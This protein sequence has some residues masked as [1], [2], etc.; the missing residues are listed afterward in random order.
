MI[1]VDV[2]LFSMKRQNSNQQLATL[3]SFAATVF[4]APLSAEVTQ[5]TEGELMMDGQLAPYVVV[6]TRTPLGLDRVSPS[7]DYIS[8]EE[9]EQWQARDLV[10]IIEK[11]PGMIIIESGGIGAQTSLF[12]RGTESNHTAFFL[13]GRRFNTGFGNQYDLSNLSIGTVGNVQVQRGASSVNYGSSG[14]GG[15]IDAQLQS[16]LDQAGT[17]GSIEAEL[18]SND[19]RRGAFT[20]SAGSERFG[21]SVSGSAL[22]TDNERANDAYGTVNLTSRFDYRLNDD[23]SLELVGQYTETFKELPNSIVS[24]TL[25]D[26]QDTE[27]WLLS[28]GIRYAT[29]ELTVHFFYS[30]AR[31][32]LDLFQIKS[33]FGPF[34]GFAYLGDFPISNT[35]KVVSDELNLQADYSVSNVLLVSAGLT[36]R[37]DEARNTN[38]NTFNPLDPAVPYNETFE[39]FGVYAH[40]LWILG[41]IELRGGLRADRYT[42][43]DNELTGSFEF[44]YNIEDLNA[45][46]FAKVATSYAPPGA[47]DIAFDSDP[48]SPLN[49]EQSES[50]E[51]GFRQALLDGDLIYSIVLFH[52]EIEELLSFDPFTFDTFNVED[53]VT[54]GVEF[55]AEYAVTEKLHLGLGYTYL[56]AE[57]DRLNDPH[58]SFAE[59]G[60]D[61][62]DGVRLARRPKHL[63]QLSADYQFTATLRGGIQAI[64]H[65]D[66]EDID[67]VS[68]LQVEAE[69]YLVVR[70]VV[71][72]AVND[73]LTLFAR[74]ENLLDE[75]YAP[76]AGFPALGR[77][78]YL[79]ARWTF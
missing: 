28:P 37:K 71:D 50:Y 52:N 29:D 26:E 67:P 34:P 59:A 35:I 4:I 12:T 48:A 43:F 61:P 17:K 11:K 41:D 13:D 8:A 20:A 30:R 14:I 5:T 56:I 44:V 53:A 33:A 3:F 69:D 6:A 76:A 78:G 79:G 47:A 21:L 36:Y 63:L 32:Q 60:V 9:I 22:S 15:V 25:E 65:F 54:Q 1:P 64:G 58:T 31:S 40:A 74:V 70:L 10:D 62:K 49:A 42:D 2:C 75:S 7:V 18:G 45:A 16:A 51:V 46:V 57:A 38:L 68:F 73:H 23:W 39:Q 66:R 72:W 24:P 19:Y 27:N 55:S 77:A